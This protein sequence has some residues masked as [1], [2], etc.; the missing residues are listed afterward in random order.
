MELKPGMFIEAGKHLDAVTRAPHSSAKGPLTRTPHDKIIQP[1][2]SKLIGLQQTGD[3]RILE[4][5]SP[6]LISASC[7]GSYFFFV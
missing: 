3:G 5:F 2:K 7:C 4:T 1:G 6:G